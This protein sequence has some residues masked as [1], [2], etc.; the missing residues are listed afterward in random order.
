MDRPTVTFV[1]PCYNL[2][3]FL[4]ECVESILA[5]GYRDFEV[6]I[7]DDCSPDNTAEVALSF[8]DSRVRHVR[9]PANLGHLANYNRGIALARGKYVWLIS[10]D[11]RLRRPYVLERYVRVMEAHPEAG[12]ACCPAVGLNGDNE[13]EVENS[14]IHHDVL[15]RGRKFLRILL[16]RGNCVIAASGMVRRECYEKLGA[17]PSDLPYAGDWF[18][19][20]L[21][22]LHYDVAYFAEPM[23]NYRHHELSM[24]TYLTGERFAIRFKDGLAVLWRIRQRVQ[25][26]GQKDLV[27][28]CRHRIAY[29]YAHN[30][31]GRGLEGSVYR[32][33]VDEFET[34]LQENA[35]AGQEADCIRART[36]VL[37]GDCHFRRREFDQARARF[38][39]ARTYGSVQLKTWAKQLLIACGL[40]DSGLT[41]MDKMLAV[42][43]RPGS[44]RAR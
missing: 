6:L 11:D 25:E 10:P 19:W 8:R 16:T 37:V 27:D 12:Y 43:R 30:I 23:V 22:A 34:S 29:Q 24:T 26:L 42:H 13:G 17:F 7:M 36:W 14:L 20:C 38:A 31:L 1:I 44:Q 4:P 33:S 9:N 21:F 32:M 41:L 5:Q 35:S 3:Q 40:G 2:A 15:F 28:L 39:L 18:L